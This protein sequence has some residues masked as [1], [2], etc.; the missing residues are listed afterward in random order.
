MAK[1]HPHYKARDLHGTHWGRLDPN[2]TPE[3]PNCGLIRN[4]ALFCE[5]SPGADEFRVEREIKKMGVSM[6]L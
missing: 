1:K 4:M 6:N 3:G 5:V 2:E